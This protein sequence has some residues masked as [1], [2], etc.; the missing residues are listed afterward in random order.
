[1][2]LP[3][4][5]KARYKP[6]NILQVQDTNKITEQTTTECGETTMVTSKQDNFML[7]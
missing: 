5:S 7:L 4:K 3:L 2:A 6:H 1:L